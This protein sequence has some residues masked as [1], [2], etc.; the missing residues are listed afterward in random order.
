M[1]ILINNWVIYP[2]PN[3]DWIFIKLVKNSLILVV[4][5]K[6]QW[7]LEKNEETTKIYKSLS[8]RLWEES[9]LLSLFDVQLSLMSLFL[10][11]KNITSMNKNAASSASLLTT[12]D[13][14]VKIYILL[15]AAL[16]S[17]FPTKKRSMVSL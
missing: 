2:L 10:F 3:G 4:T 1:K 11:L 8:K 13:N 14:L 7:S 15:V 5:T 17:N 12:I 16:A 6:R 9:D